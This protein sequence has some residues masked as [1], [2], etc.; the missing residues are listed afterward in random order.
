MSCNAKPTQ[1]V[2]SAPKHVS[3]SWAQRIWHDL[4]YWQRQRT[5][6]KTKVEER[7]KRQGTTC[8]VLRTLCCEHRMDAWRHSACLRQ[9]RSRKS[10]RKETVQKETSDV[11]HKRR[12]H[13]GF[14]L[15]MV[16]T[17]HVFVLNRT[18][19]RRRRVNG[20]KVF[21]LPFNAPQE[22]VFIVVVDDVVDG[23]IRKGAEQQYT[24][25]L[26]H[27]DVDD[28][29][30]V[31]VTHTNHLAVF[32]WIEWAEERAIWCVCKIPLPMQFK[33]TRMS[34]TV[35]HYNK[36][37]SNVCISPFHN[38]LGCRRATYSRVLCVY[39]VHQR[40]QRRLH[41]NFDC[42]VRC[43]VPTKCVILL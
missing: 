22:S 5:N 13:C 1:S 9:W 36:L 31:L 34:K 24:H 19:T 40:R 7:T 12:F 21:V 33:G 4:A 10:L 26:A 42:I 18:T 43:S 41:S 35:E 17:V 8:Y 3:H 2:R 6:E 29:E 14:R 15:R 20:I 28:E 38:A 11:Q 37:K 25:V 23:L 39:N 32:G 16:Y 27:N 30:L